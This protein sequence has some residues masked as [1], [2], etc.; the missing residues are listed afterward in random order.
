MVIFISS[1]AFTNPS[2]QQLIDISS[3]LNINFE[4]SANICYE[5]DIDNKLKNFRGKFLIH[6]YFPL[7]KKEFVINLASSNEDIRKK[8]I[9]FA[10]E[11]IFRCKNF[12]IP[13]YSIH[14]GFRFDPIP[15]ELGT[16]FKS[17]KLDNYESS[18]NLF[19]R[20]ILKILD[21]T[22][23]TNV[24]FLLENNVITAENL[25]AFNQNPLLC[26]D[27]N[28]YIKIFEIIDNKRLGILADFGHL[29]VSAKTL[30]FNLESFYE[31]LK[32]KIFAHHLSSNNS[33]HDTN[34]SFK[35]VSDFERIEY[36]EKS[37]YITLEINNISCEEIIEQRDLL[38]S[39]IKVK[40]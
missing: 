9:K 30:N 5:K 40:K 32:D 31:I 2:L 38:Q 20:S 39:F 25:I 27:K 3:E 17:M 22:S 18:F 15:N 4:L 14:S 13:I 16:K 29:K 26:C 33:L 19:V 24:R 21:T 11:N 1:V 34:E 12:N 8:S 6:N 10:I 28:D 36:I 35:N 23:D 7:P 37:E